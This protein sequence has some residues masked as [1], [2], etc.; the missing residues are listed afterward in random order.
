MCLELYWLRYANCI[1]SATEDNSSMAGHL[2][3]P[4]TANRDGDGDGVIVTR[5]VTQHNSVL[6]NTEAEWSN[7]P[8][9]SM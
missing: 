7:L 6:D 3:P 5:H 9:L 8:A 4:G 2:R 1:E